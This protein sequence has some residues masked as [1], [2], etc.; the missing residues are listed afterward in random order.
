MV[1]YPLFSAI[2][3]SHNIVKPSCRG[4]ITD[5]MQIIQEEVWVGKAHLSL[6]PQLKCYLK[7]VDQSDKVGGV[8]T[9]G[10]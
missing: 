4:T 6:L 8:G 3:H 5:Q 7:V 2:F 9:G 10:L 1:Y